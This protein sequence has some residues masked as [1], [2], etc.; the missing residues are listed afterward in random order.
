MEQKLK[1][2]GKVRDIEY[3]EKLYKNKRLYLQGM[4]CT[5]TSFQ[6]LKKLVKA[7][8][9]IYP[10]TWDFK[11]RV[12]KEVNLDILGFIIYFKEVKIKN[13]TPGAFHIIRD[14]FFFTYIFN[15]ETHI[16]LSLPSFTRTTITSSEEI[17]RYLHSH[18]MRAKLFEQTGEMFFSFCTGSG[19]IN[20]NVNNLQRNPFNEDNLYSYLLNLSALISWESVDTNPYILF[21]SIT[22][23]YSGYSYNTKHD[24]SIDSLLKSFLVDLKENNISLPFKINKNTVEIYNKDKIKKLLVEFLILGKFTETD[25]LCFYSDITNE[26][27]K[28]QPK[29][30]EEIKNHNEK[31]VYTDKTYVDF[32]GE[33]FYLTIDDNISKE[34][35]EQSINNI[36]PT[37]HITDFRKIIHKLNYEANS[38]KILSQ[39]R[40]K[41]YENISKYFRESTT[42]D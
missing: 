19:P 26:W 10:D 3:L 30:L 11:I 28:F 23:S 38:E 36:K 9:F 18:C 29:I 37:I 20:N 14:S 32:R 34:E 27:L 33:R 25:F 22:S 16:E 6:E 40:E 21:S 41:K 17:S 1:K 4:L 7:C 35:I 24:S 42:T 5:Y 15:R 39:I 2:S 8:N 12:F 31:T 13:S